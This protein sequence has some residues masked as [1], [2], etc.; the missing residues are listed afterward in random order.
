MAPSLDQQTAMLSVL[1]DQLASAV[2]GLAS[3]RWLN[4]TYCPATEQNL[5][6]VGIMS[7]GPPEALFQVCAASEQLRCILR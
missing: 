1:I 6:N 4:L 2:T 3:L 5:F 7:V